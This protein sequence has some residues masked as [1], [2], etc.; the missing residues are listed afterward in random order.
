MIVQFGCVKDLN[1]FCFI[2]VTVLIPDSRLCA[3][4]T[5]E[6][7]WTTLLIPGRCFKD[8]HSEKNCRRL[9][10]AVARD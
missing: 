1:V 2:G 6:A 5:S 3:H 4:L 10:G 9:V 7:F 8:C